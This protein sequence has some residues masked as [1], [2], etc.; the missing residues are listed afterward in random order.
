MSFLYYCSV[1]T[2]AAVTA[3]F[4]KTEL[5]VM[6][7]ESTGQTQMK[8]QVKDKEARLWSVGKGTNAATPIKQK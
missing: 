8:R 6:T 2:S 5:R 1:L 3:E 4:G 7:R